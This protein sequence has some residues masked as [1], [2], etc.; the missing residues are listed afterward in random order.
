MSDI[1][2]SV[3]T[4]IVTIFVRK[5]SYMYLQPCLGTQAEIHIS[6]ILDPL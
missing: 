2:I 6:L 4:L 1:H 5:F 3:I